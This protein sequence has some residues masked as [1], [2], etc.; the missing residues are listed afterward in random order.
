MGKLRDKLRE[1]RDVRREKLKEIINKVA[2]SDIS[3]E[4]LSEISNAAQGTHDVV[5]DTAREH[6]KGMKDVRTSAIAV[7]LAG[8]VYAGLTG[9]ADM[10]PEV[11][12]LISSTIAIVFQYIK[13]RAMNRRKM[14]ALAKY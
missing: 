8:I 11:S 5:H 1:N 2:S 12:G 13:K 4:I 14:R 7:T 10:S 3:S 9:G 6:K